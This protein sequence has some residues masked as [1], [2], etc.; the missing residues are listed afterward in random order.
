MTLQQK[1]V[2]A[3]EHVRGLLIDRRADFTHG[4]RVALEHVVA[5]AD[6]Y[7]QQKEQTDA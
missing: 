6:L 3:L 4:D 5:M 1:R 2:Q 7:Q